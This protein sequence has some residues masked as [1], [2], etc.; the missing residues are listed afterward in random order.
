MGRRAG[1]YLRRP[2]VEMT[3]FSREIERNYY[4]WGRELGK[5]NTY[6]DPTW[7]DATPEERLYVSRRGY[8]LYDGCPTATDN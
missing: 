2:D 3:D 5:G 4:D 6:L 7:N 1:I 8:D